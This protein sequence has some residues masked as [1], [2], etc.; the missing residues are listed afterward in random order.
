MAK[1]IPE[2]HQL[3]LDMAENHDYSNVSEGHV[4]YEID[5]ISVE[6]E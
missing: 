5:L 1:S 4:G 6:G 3:A 2:A